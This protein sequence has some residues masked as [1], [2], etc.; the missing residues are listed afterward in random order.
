MVPSSVAGQDQA[1]DVVAPH[2]LG[3]GTRSLVALVGHS[4]GPL[5][6]LG[7]SFRQ[8]LA[9]VVRDDSGKLVLTGQVGLRGAQ[10]RPKVDWPGG[11][12]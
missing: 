11:G 5:A 7:D 1:R 6:A 2:Y 12:I 4:T 10:P 3:H 9:Y 8:G